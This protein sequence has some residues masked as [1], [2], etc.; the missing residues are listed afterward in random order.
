[1]PIHEVSS[2]S[3]YEQCLIDYPNSIV[4][5]GAEW[6]GPCKTMDKVIKNLTT[7]KHI[8]LVDIDTEDI[9]DYIKMAGLK[10]KTI[11]TVFKYVNGKF[12]HIEC[13]ANNFIQKCILN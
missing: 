3:E 2:V 7:D 1:M 13:N 4:K 12:I 8:I 6:C 11:P 5:F 9:L 10:F